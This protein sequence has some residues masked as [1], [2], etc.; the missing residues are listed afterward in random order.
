M[1]IRVYWGNLTL[2][3]VLINFFIPAMQVEPHSEQDLSAYMEK[4]PTERYVHNRASLDLDDLPETRDA[5]E[6]GGTGRVLLQD[7]GSGGDGGDNEDE[8]GSSIFIAPT[9]AD[10]QKTVNEGA[11]RNIFRV[12]LQV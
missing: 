10:C 9:E 6:K 7:G 11:N 12:Q 8:G 1:S 3:I 2:T 4:T 5:E